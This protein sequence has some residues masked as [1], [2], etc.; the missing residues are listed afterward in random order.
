MSPQQKGGKA[1]SKKYAPLYPCPHCGK[2]YPVATPYM[3][4]LGHMGLHGLANRYFGGDIR[5]AQRRLS[6]NGR[7][8]QEAGASWSN[9]AFKP[10]RPVMDQCNS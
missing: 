8:R 10:Y 5:A 7:A 1:V 4:W 6:D 9:G 3:A 2:V